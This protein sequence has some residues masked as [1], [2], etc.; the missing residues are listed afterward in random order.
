M[1]AAI[2]R[3]VLPSAE[4]QKDNKYKASSSSWQLWVYKVTKGHHATKL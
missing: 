1:E 3:Q 2:N 4:V